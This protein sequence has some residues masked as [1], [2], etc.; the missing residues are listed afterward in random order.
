M[1]RC[2]SSASPTTPSARPATEAPQASRKSRRFMNRP[3]QSGLLA[4]LV[5]SP[6]APAVAIILDE[7]GLQLTLLVAVAFQRGKR[8][9]ADRLA[10][11]PPDGLVFGRTPHP[12]DTVLAGV[13]AHPLGVGVEVSAQGGQRLSAAPVGR[14]HDNFDLPLVEQ[15]AAPRGLLHQALIIAHDLVGVGVEHVDEQR[16]LSL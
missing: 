5:L 4:L 12:D 9:L 15:A 2:A 14:E 11:R 1:G 10:P 8:Y 3:P 16:R 7:G 13:H 6:L